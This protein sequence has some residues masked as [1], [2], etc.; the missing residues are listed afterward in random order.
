MNIK[1]QP[2]SRKRPGKPVELG[3]VYFFAGPRQHSCSWFLAYVTHDHI[4]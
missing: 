2:T 1:L 3:R 4:L